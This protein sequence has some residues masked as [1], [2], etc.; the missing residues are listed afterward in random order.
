MKAMLAM[1]HPPQTTALRPLWWL[2]V[3]T[4][5]VLAA[6][7]WAATGASGPWPAAGEA[8]ATPPVLPYGAGFEQRLRAARST[9]QGSPSLPAAAPD[10]AGPVRN[11]GFGRGG[12]GGSGQGGG[13][14]GGGR[15][16]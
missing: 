15:G 11:S 7:T 16:R 8:E 12:A 9:A 4:L 1:Q 3:A 6:P 13:G 2:G 14:G 10:G 5:A